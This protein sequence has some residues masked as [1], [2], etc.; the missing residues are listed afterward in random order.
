V[1]GAI[2][3]L[4][5]LALV[6]PAF[7]ARSDEVTTVFVVDVSAS[8]GDS[9]KEAARAWAES[10]LTDAGDSRWGVVEFGA[11][12]RVG[13]PVGTEPY[14]RARGVETDATNPPAACARRIGSHRRDQTANR[15]RVR[16][17]GQQR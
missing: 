1:R 7:T 3:V 8:M 5:V 17:Q 11:D 2:V 14:R 10:A 15:A 4:L 6:N 9:A 13:I 12:A 16:R